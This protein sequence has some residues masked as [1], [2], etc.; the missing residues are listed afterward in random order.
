MPQ[1]WLMMSTSAPDASSGRTTLSNRPRICSRAC[2]D[3]QLVMVISAGRHPMASGGA[4]EQVASPGRP[5]RRLGA[6][7]R[8][9]SAGWRAASP[10]AAGLPGCGRAKSRRTDSA[11]RRCSSVRDR[12]E[13]QTCGGTRL[14]GIKA[15]AI[16]GLT[17]SSTTTRAHVVGGNLEVYIRFHRVPPRLGKP[18]VVP[19]D[20]VDVH[21]VPVRSGRAKA[22]SAQA[23]GRSGRTRSSLNCRPADVGRRGRVGDLQ[24]KEISAADI[25]DGPQIDHL[26]RVVTVTRVLTQLG[27]S[28]RGPAAGQEISHRRSSGQLATSATDNLE[29]ASSRARKTAAAAPVAIKA[30]ESKNIAGIPLRGDELVAGAFPLA[31]FTR[32]RTCNSPGSSGQVP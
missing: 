21:E 29:R 28:S 20:A 5:V 32:I 23:A 6:A 19:A 30:A 8:G 11:S 13:G 9:G 15:A 18:W 14:A 27:K 4:T 2:R 22:T 31:R 24:L 7:P 10:A 25:V 17:M 3:R 26:A 12:R 1:L 16:A